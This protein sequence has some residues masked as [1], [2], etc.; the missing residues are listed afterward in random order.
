MRFIYYPHKKIKEDRQK[1]K[2]E[3]NN[4]PVTIVWFSSTW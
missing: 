1:K 3:E 4:I 2:E